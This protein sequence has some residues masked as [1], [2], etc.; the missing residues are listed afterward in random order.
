MFRQD[1][2]HNF[3]IEDQIHIEINSILDIADLFYNIFGLKYSPA[4]STRP[5]D[6][7]GDTALWDKVKTK[8]KAVLDSRYG[9]D[10]Y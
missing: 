3:I 4:L 10:G 9:K 8:L 1:D 6:F 2:S 5:K 7:M